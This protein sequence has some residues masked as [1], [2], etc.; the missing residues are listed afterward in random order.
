MK[1]TQH[2]CAGCGTPLPPPLMNIGT[3]AQWCGKCMVRVLRKC[4]TPVDLL[5]KVPPPKK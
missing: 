2:K 4:K 3:A 5:Q 1:P